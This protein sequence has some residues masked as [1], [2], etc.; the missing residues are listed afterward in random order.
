MRSAVTRVL[1]LHG[2]L[3]ATTISGVCGDTE[4]NFMSVRKNVTKEYK[5]ERAIPKEKYFHESEFNHHYD[6][7]YANGSL[8][9]TKVIPYLSDLI[10]TY[11]TTMNA[12]GAETWIMHGT[13]LAWWWNQKV[14][15]WDDDLDVQISEATIHFL[16]D[17]YNMTEHHFDL[18]NVDGGRTYMLEI[19][20]HYVVKSERDTLNKIDARWIDMSSGLF[21]DITAV[22]KDE[23]KR[24][25]GH[26]EALMCKDKHHYEES[27]I[28]PLRDSLFEGVPVKIPYAYTYLLE[29]EYGPKALTRTS[30]YGHIFNEQTKIW[31]SAVR[32]F[33]R[34]LRRGSRGNNLPMNTPTLTPAHID[35]A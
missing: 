31:E 32:K 26:P 24:L 34:S 19:N 12:I 5:S 13:L 16:A 2:F 8:P 7:R 18:P 21:I 1:W 14:F 11:F 4:P 6:G 30:F 27:D 23:A 9:D 20:P 17:Y 3:L 33:K 29:E 28:F 22:R 25:N 10:Q 35:E 15:P